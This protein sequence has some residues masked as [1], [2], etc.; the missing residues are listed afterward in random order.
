[1]TKVGVLRTSSAK[2]G[3]DAV[4]EP[5][6]P[7]GAPRADHDAQ[8]GAQ[9]RANDQQPQADSDAAPQIRWRPAGRSMVVPK[10]PRTAC[11]TQCA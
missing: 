8:D 3:D 5:V 6:L 11:V 10:S 7:D 2:H 9:H 4:A 1:M